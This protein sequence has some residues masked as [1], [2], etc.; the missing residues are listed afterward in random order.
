[1]GCAH[2]TKTQLAVVVHSCNPR[3]LGAE[4]GEAGR[5]LL[6]SRLGWSTIVSSRT[7]RATHCDPVKQKDKMKSLHNSV[8]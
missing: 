5:S 7:V 6:S 4:I 1:M 3:T 8:K 2:K